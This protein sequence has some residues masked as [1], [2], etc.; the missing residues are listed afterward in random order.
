M[1]HVLL[2]DD[3]KLMREGLAAILRGEID[4]EIIAEASNGVEAIEQAKVRKPDVVIM[5]LT[6]PDMGGVEATKRI[7]SDNPQIQ[8]LVLT[9]FLDEYCVCESLEAGARGYLI[10]DCASEELVAAIHAIHQGKPYFCAE[11]QEIMMSKISPASSTG[12]PLN[13]LTNRELEVLKL[14]ASGS[15]TK[16]IAFHLGLSTKTVEVHR[17]KAKK[18]LG[19]HSIAQLTSY[20]I[21]AGLIP[22]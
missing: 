17:M 1:I 22:S 10:K 13:Q 8:I 7:L 14:T 20:A 6:L 5:D 9:M 12:R 16:E 15:N 18:K 3:H 19:L 2:V 11:A 21:K 4:I